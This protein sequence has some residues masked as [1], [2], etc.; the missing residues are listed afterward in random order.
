DDDLAHAFYP[1]DAV[2]ARRWGER[3]G[4]PSVFWYGGVPQRNVIASRRGRVRVLVEAIGGCDAVVVSSHAAARG[5]KRW[6]DVEARVIYPGV[7]LEEFAAGIRRADQPTIACAADPDDARKRISLLVE[8]FHAV[9]RVRADARLLLVR[10]RNE[11][12]ARALTEVDGVELVEQTPGTP[13]ELFH[14][15]WVSALAAYNEAFGLVLV[16]SLACGA[17][18]VGMNDGGVPEIIDDNGIGRLFDGSQEDLTRAL[19]EA[20]D[21]AA[22]PGTADRCRARAAEFTTARTAEDSLRLYEELL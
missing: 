12:T 7:R 8:A 10:P 17:P 11:A 22:D 18:A 21:L 6:F 20:L 1:T 14:R 4:R 16:E 15:T 13:A 2:V 5:I 19:L 9:R 3:R